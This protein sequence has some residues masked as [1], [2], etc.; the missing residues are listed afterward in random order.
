MKLPNKPKVLA[1]TYNPISN[2]KM[3]TVMVDIPYVLL[4]ELLQFKELNVT[5]KKIEDI[6]LQEIV[7]NLYIPIWTKKQG[8]DSELLDNLVPNQMWLEF[9]KGCES[10]MSIDVN[11]NTT[12]SQV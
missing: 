5:Y 6:Q 1:A 7:D 2:T 10:K 9:L 3:F 12:I 11:S 8:M 4:P